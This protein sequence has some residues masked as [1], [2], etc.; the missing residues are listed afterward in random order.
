MSQELEETIFQKEFRIR[1]SRIQKSEG[2]TPDP[3]PLNLTSYTPSEFSLR[4]P[5][6]RYPLPATRYSLLLARCAPKSPSRSLLPRGA[7]FSSAAERSKP[8]RLGSRRCCSAAWI[9]S[10]KRLSRR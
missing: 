1:E 8:G 5:A 2:R 6:T 9:A 3:F 4:L 10:A 7:L